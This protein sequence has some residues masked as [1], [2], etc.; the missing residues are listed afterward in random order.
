MDNL[1]EIQDL[2]ALPLSPLAVL[3]VKRLRV[4]GFMPGSSTLLATAVRLKFGKLLPVNLD[5]CHRSLYGEVRSTC[6]I[7]ASTGADHGI[8]MRQERKQVSRGFLDRRKSLM[9]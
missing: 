4:S 1:H 9:I 6:Y 3:Y 8:L 7:N 5:H 2:Y